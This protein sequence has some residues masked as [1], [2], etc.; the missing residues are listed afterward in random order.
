MNVTPE[1]PI[2][3]EGKGWLN[4]EKLVIGDRLRQIDGGWVAE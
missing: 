4:A 2:Y 3:I 1:H